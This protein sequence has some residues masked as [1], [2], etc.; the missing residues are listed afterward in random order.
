MAGFS[1]LND[2]QSVAIDWRWLAPASESLFVP[3]PFL[4]MKL[5]TR[6]GIHV[7]ASHG[8][9]TMIGAHV[10]HGLLLLDSSSLPAEN[11]PVNNTPIFLCH[12][13]DH[14]FVS[15]YFGTGKNWLDFSHGDEAKESGNIRD[16][17]QVLASLFFW[18]IIFSPRIKSPIKMTHFFDSQM[19][20]S[21]T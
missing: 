4:A 10:G 7:I 11:I 20:S 8:I 1:L 21:T 16:V 5:I 15:V 6:D 17:F 18:S 13:M 3:D 19:G 12:K 14:E 2:D 9:W